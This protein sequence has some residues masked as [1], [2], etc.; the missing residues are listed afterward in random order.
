MSLAELQQVTR[1][2]GGPRVRRETPDNKA[3]L[4]FLGP[5]LVG[6]V[7]LMIGPLLASLYLAFTDYNLL[8]DPG[9]VG[10][11]NFTRML[12]DER[13][14]QSLKVTFTYVLVGV[15]AQLVVALLLAVVLDRGMRGS[16]PAL[17]TMAVGH[18]G[19][20]RERPPVPPRSRHPR[21]AYP[22][23]RRSR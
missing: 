5:W 12:G 3:A 22:L 11:D 14:H 17:G 21:R 19:S 20:L 18:A 13:L 2:R 4:V 16:G 7:V 9:F 15:P 1:R 23:R 8:Q 10:L 6:A